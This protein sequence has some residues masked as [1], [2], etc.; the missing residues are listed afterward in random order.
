MRPRRGMPEIDDSVWLDLMIK[1]R[2]PEDVHEG[3]ASMTTEKD[4]YTYLYLDFPP[5]TGELPPR[6]G[7]VEW[8][9]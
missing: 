7:P 4:G 2:R 5:P 6:A 3:K 8:A 9:P 1:F